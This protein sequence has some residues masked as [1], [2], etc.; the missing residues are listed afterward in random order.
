MKKAIFLKFVSIAVSITILFAMSSIFSF[1]ENFCDTCVLQ[2]D[3]KTFGSDATIKNVTAADTMNNGDSSGVFFDSAE[4]ILNLSKFDPRDELTPVKDQGTSNLCWAYS[5]INAS[6]ASILKNKIGTKNSLSLNPQALAYR[7][8]VRNADLLGNNAAY[9]GKGANEWFSSAGQTEQTS[10]VLSMWQG[11]VGGNRYDA[12]VFE[13][14]LYRL[15]SANLI[16]SEATGDERITEIKRAIA[17]YGAVTASCYYDGGTKQYYNDNAVSNGISHAI[18]LIGWDDDIDKNLFEPG[19]KVNRNGGW[20]VKNSY[21]D[22]G[23]F[24]LTYESKIA[25]STAWT[26][27]Y[28]P[29]E[30]YDYNYYYDNSET[31]FG[32]SKIKQVANVFEA[33]NGT[34]DKSEYI[35][36]VNLGFTGNDVCVKV[37][38]YTNL[39]GCDE[40]SVESGTLA[41][42][43]T[44]IFKY[45]GYNTVKLNTPVKIAPGSYFS[46]VTE[47]SDKK[48]DASVKTVLSESKKPSFQKTSYGYD[49]I[50]YGGRVARVKAY[51]VLRDAGAGCVIHN[52][53]NLISEVYPTCSETGIA[54][55]YRCSACCKY[56]DE[57]K[58]EVDY[59]SLKIAINP[60]AHD[61]SVW[62]TEKPANCSEPGIKGHK[63]CARC[64]KH[65]DNNGNVIADLTIA[66]N[67][68]H[69]W[70]DAVYTW[71][72]D[73]ECKAERVCLL[74]LGHIESETVTANARVI[75]PA[76]CNAK[77]VTEY[78]TNAFAN[79]AF[80]VQ[81]RKAEINY[82]PHTFGEWI[83]EVPATADDF[84]IKAHKDCIV[85]M[86]HFDEDGNEIND[87]KIT[88]IAVYKVTVNGGNGSGYYKKGKQITVTADVP[89]GKEFCGWRDKNGDIVASDKAYTFIVDGE[90][91]LTT[92][93]CDKS[94][95]SAP[96]EQGCNAVASSDSIKSTLICVFVVLLLVFKR[97]FL[98]Q[99]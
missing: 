17:E 13:N 81:S 1:E 70:G 32:L 60:N 2:S 31:D 87:L 99:S 49:Y 62:I 14:S 39:S 55:H 34:V 19:K 89:E 75:I 41:A 24:W 25:S 82:A 66:V 88:K 50:A 78:T 68:M 38:V 96:G 45:G 90:V 43:E 22:N 16:L 23:Y 57:N 58:N 42:E 12:D 33:K 10:A 27:T 9:I 63:D 28:A 8:Y 30:A 36:A 54:A 6:E 15:E 69:D 77:G 76:A 84:G 94:G 37:K 83:P 97:R 47:V 71:I 93:Y 73:D 26:F 59:E 21:N 44:R 79:S 85:C 46:I 52:Y 67:G 40:S 18:T 3:M 7:K 64:N 53:G 92:V 65:F 51:T 86:K 29:K 35:E 56:F 98:K 91:E 20:L 5:A 80:T 4:K 61:F 11:P 95:E 72:S 48:G 74:D